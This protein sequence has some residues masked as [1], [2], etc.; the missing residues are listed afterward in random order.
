MTRIGQVAEEALLFDCS[1][2]TACG[3]LSLPSAPATSGVVIVVGG[4]QYRAGSHRQFVHLARALAAA[5]HAVLRFDV[6]GMGDSS[7]EPRAFDAVSDDI[8]AAIDALQRTVPSIERVVLWGLCDAASA[9]LLYWHQTRDA[10]VGGMVLLNP[11]VRSEV[12]L[13]RT[14]VKH[15]Y[16]ERLLEPAFWR[17]LLKGKVALGA[18]SG[19]LGNLRKATSRGGEP[20]GAALPFQARM[21]VACNEFAGSILLIMS[22]NDY[23]AREFEE[24]ARGDRPWAQALARP[25]VLRRDVAEADHTFSNATARRAVEEWTCEW[26]QSVQPWR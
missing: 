12:T 5:G 19:L 8:K 13:A 6:R 20:A 1:G 18:I 22:A 17:K 14:Q 16:R 23:T 4:P 10:R 26:L 15:Y 2:E 21:A 3:I 9:A 11:W 7:G 25:Q 24:Y